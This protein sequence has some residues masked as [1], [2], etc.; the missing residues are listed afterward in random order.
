YLVPKSQSPPASIAGGNFEEAKKA[1]SSLIQAGMRGK[2]VSAGDSFVE[3]ELP[4]KTKFLVGKGD[5]M[6]ARLV[7]YDNQ[8][9][10][11]SAITA[12]KILTLRAR[13]APLPYLLIGGGTF[14]A[15]VLGLLIVAVARGG[16]GRKRGGAASPPRPG[17][18]PAGFAPPPVGAP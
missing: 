7:L 1:Q 13:E 15:V 3:F 18:A 17:L 12:D 16:G 2:A 5:K 4:D 14:A 6:T 10:R 8:A 11:T 9:R